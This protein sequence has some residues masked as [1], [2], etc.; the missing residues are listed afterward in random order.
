MTE[1]FAVRPG[2]ADAVWAAAKVRRFRRALAVGGVALA[3]I[4]AP[5]A[6]T[7]L[8]DGG[9]AD[10]LTADSPD[11]THRVTD[12]APTGSADPSPTP[13]PSASE[14]PG[15]SSG[16]EPTSGGEPS[17]GESPEP[18][19]AGAGEPTEQP[20]PKRRSAA[21]PITRGAG[22]IETTDL[23]DGGTLDPTRTAWCARYTG[24]TTAKRGQPVTLSFELCR[25]PQAGDAT[26][27]YDSEL[28]ILA[29][30]PGPADQPRWRAGQ[31]VVYEKRPHSEVVRAGTCLAWSSSW[32]TRG[33]DGFLVV[34]GSYE[35]Y[36][37][38][39]NSGGLPGASGSFEVVS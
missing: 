12:P 33:S 4:G 21:A 19:E 15:G 22:T 24:P 13:D 14:S 37:R 31:G 18:E 23:C 39:N 7:V 3:V 10:S 28:E 30:V 36:G 20:R 5:L 17:P 27:T 9:G 6:T 25:Y 2:A 26:V 32:D 11:V 34:P 35:F 29:E 1:D 8:R 16:S 38:V